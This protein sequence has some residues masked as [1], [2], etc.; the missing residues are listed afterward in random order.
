M[1][2]EY[3]AA[4]WRKMQGIVD[5]TINGAIAFIKSMPNI[6]LMALT[7]AATAVSIGTIAAQKLPERPPKQALGGYQEGN[8]HALGGKIVEVEG[9]E[10]IINK[11]S[12]AQYLPLLEAINN[13][14]IRKFAEGGTTAPVDV[15]MSPQLFDYDKLADAILGGIQPTVSVVEINRMQQKVRV[16][17]NNARIKK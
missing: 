3:Q 4:K 17:Q 8:S 6:L 10:Y 12:T 15:S 11:K 7:A 2:A 9:G 5:A 14:G 1:E 16:L 13:A